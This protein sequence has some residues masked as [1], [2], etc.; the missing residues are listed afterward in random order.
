VLAD[1]LRALLPNNNQHV[2]VYVRGE[3]LGGCDIVLEL[4]AA[5]ELKVNVDEMLHRMQDTD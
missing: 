2:Q 1:N 4:Q 5:G 3:L